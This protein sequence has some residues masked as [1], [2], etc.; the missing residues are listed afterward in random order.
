MNLLDT[1]WVL[2]AGLLVFFMNAG[3][4]FV[5]SG[6]VRTKNVVNVL[7]KN[8]IVFALSTFAFWTIGYSVMFY[9]GFSAI[10]YS[11][12]NSLVGPENHK[13]SEMAFFFF[14]LAFAG[15][16][17]T[18]VSGAVAERIKFMA[19][20]V[21]SLLLVAVIYPIVGYF[22]WGPGPLS[23]ASF[24]F[25]DFAGSTVVH[26]IGGWA[27]LAGVIV[28]GPRLGKYSGG[29]IN[30]IPGHS[31]PL[32]TLG[33]FIL[34]LGWFGFNPGSEL[35][36][37]EAVPLIAMNTNLAAIAAMLSATAVS[38]VKFKK[39]DYSLMMNGLLAGLVAITAGCY[40]VTPVGAFLIGLMAG[41]LLIFGV[42]FFDRIGIDDPVGATSV[43][44]LNGVFGTL[45]VGFFSATD[46]MKGLFYG[47]G[48]AQI[49]KQLTGIGFTALVVFPASLII[50]LIIRMI[51]GVRVSEKEEIEGLDVGE[52][53]TEAYNS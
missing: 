11:A 43:H 29:K 46:G 32:A 44:L 31:I 42:G 19:Y 48:T 20:I 21:F 27:A 53:G 45:M 52:M 28:L 51:L 12:V 18:I 40:D 5:E 2:I 4:A 47:G 38:W 7:A 33:T 34:W 3:F 26:S 22:L 13:I 35:A 37:D 9:G 6:F 25:I 14:Q 24:G 50:W 23:R 39:P 10:F 1:M 41:V 16:A 36:F 17:A 49:V 30:A 8:F 15:T